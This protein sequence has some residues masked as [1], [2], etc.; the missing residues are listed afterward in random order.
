[1]SQ[2]AKSEIESLN[3]EISPDKEE[4]GESDHSGTPNLH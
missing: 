4:I 3:Y 1:M 2:R